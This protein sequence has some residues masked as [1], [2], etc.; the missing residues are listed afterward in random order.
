MDK[1]SRSCNVLTICS[2]EHWVFTMLASS[3]L[4]LVVQDIIMEHIAESW[5]EGAFR[6]F[7]AYFHSNS[8]IAE[9]ALCQYYLYFYDEGL[10]RWLLWNPS[11]AAVWLCRHVYYSVGEAF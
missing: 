7:Y 3:G 8:D 2:R 1:H 4:Q 11:A 9:Y 10:E 6:T 5:D